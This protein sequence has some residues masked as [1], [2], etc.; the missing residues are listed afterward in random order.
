MDERWHRQ[1]WPWKFNTEIFSFHKEA[2]VKIFRG[3]TEEFNRES[4]VQIDVHW[5][6]FNS[7]Y[8]KPLSFY[9]L[10][11]L[12]RPETYTL[13][14]REPLSEDHLLVRRVR[15][16]RKG[17]GQV[18][19]LLTGLGALILNAADMNDK[20][21]RSNLWRGNVEVAYDRANFEARI[22]VLT[23]EWEFEDKTMGRSVHFHFNNKAERK[24]K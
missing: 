8:K 20:Q 4:L 13:G 16:N 6:L 1:V 22:K 12:G 11:E 3:I 18:T 2:Q 10:V 9:H 14:E 23:N 5:K 7:G 17:G 19:G 24:H 15:F 21:F